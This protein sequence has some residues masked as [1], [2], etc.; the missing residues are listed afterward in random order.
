M[1]LSSTGTTGGASCFIDLMS[2]GATPS[3][4]SGNPRWGFAILGNEE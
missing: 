3:I 2:A 4:H 1:P